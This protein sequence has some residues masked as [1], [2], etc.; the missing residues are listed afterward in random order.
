MSRSTFSHGNQHQAGIRTL[1]VQSVSWAFS[2]RWVNFYLNATFLTGVYS[3]LENESWLLLTL[4]LR[5]TSKGEKSGRLGAYKKSIPQS[6]WRVFGAQIRSPDIHRWFW[7]QI[8]RW[9]W[10]SGGLTM[11]V[12]ACQVMLAKMAIFTHNSLWCWWCHWALF[13]KAKCGLLFVSHV[14]VPDTVL[15]S[16]HS[17]E[18]KFTGEK[19]GGKA[20]LPFCRPWWSYPDWL[21]NCCHLRPAVPPRL[22]T[23]VVTP[24]RCLFPKTQKRTEYIPVGQHYI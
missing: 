1:G 17:V 11:G 22:H 4:L 23:S 20:G 2:N 7:Q 6:P 19:K 9:G 8:W 14:L 15:E 10:G 16:L 5:K 18:H 12:S 24:T 3:I 13:E 21:L